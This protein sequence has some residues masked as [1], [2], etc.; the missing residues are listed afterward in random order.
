MKKIVLIALLLIQ[1]LEITYTSFL[2][3]Q[4]T[5]FFRKSAVYISQASQLPNEQF[6]DAQIDDDSPTEDTSTVTTNIGTFEI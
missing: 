4:N 5:L 2:L 6:D 3:S 1:G